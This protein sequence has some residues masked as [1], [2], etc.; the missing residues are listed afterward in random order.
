MALTWSGSPWDL[1]A[2]SVVNFVLSI[3][4]LRIYSFWG[5]TEVRRRIWSSIHV[6]GEPLA[7]S[8][9]GKELLLGFVLVLAV[10]LLP[11]VVLVT[12]AVISFGPVDPR[13]KAV[14]LVLYVGYFFLFGIA[15]YRARR[16]RLSRTL[17]RGIRGG[18]SGSATS[19]AWLSFCT[20]LLVPVTLGW[21]VPRLQRRLTSETTFGNLPFAYEGR[22]APLYARF[23][24]LW[25]GGIAIYAGALA[26]I[27]VILGPRLAA[28]AE[29]SRAGLPHQLSP[30]DVGVMVVIGLV[31]LIVF[32]IIG[33]WYQA[34][35][36]NLFLSYTGFSEARLCANTSALG[37]IGLF[38]SN[39]LIILGSVSVFDS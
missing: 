19:Y 28:Q 17:W 31:A 2:L 36:F 23:A 14:Q 12:A 21:I 1:V 38:V 39:L 5:K 3:L 16:Y 18:M 25:I 13:T 24:G 15:I 29:A 30:A 37:L 26:A 8:G 22:S 33:A 9:I 7:Y 6:D 35:Q 34:K 10:V 20:A 4:T 27:A 32:S 11:T